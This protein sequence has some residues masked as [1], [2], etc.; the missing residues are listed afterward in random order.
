[1]TTAAASIL[2]LA[3][4]IVAIAYFLWA[5]GSTYPIRDKALV[6][7]AID[8]RPGVERL[9]R[10]GA[11]GVAVFALVAAGIGTALGDTES[12]GLVLTIVGAVVGLLF[13]VRG[14]LGYTAG[15][16]AAHPVEPFASLDRRYYS[17]LCLVVAA[18]FAILVITRLT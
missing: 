3:L 8:G 12:G 11:F 15:W 18:C 16:R 9:S 6:A 17:P 10:A 1:M 5:I 13:A 14:V 2:F 7:R 4:L